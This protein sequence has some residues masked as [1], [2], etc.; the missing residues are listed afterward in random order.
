[1]TEDIKKD[2]NNIPKE[3]KFQEE[4]NELAMLYSLILNNGNPKTSIIFKKYAFHV[5][6][7]VYK[8]GYILKETNNLIEDFFLFSPKEIKISDTTFKA[9]NF[10]S[11]FAFFN[12]KKIDDDRIYLNDE[13]FNIMTIFANESKSFDFLL[14]AKNDINLGEYKVTKRVINLTLLSELISPEK[15]YIKFS[16]DSFYLSNPERDKLINDIGYHVNKKGI[17]FI[18]GPSGLGKTVTFLKF[19]HQY[20]N[21]LYINLKDIFSSFEIREIFDSLVSELSFLFNDDTKFNE[22]IQKE[23]LPI[24]QNKILYDGKEVFCELLV[25][26]IKTITIIN[27]KKGKLYIIIDQYKLCYDESLKIKNIL[28]NYTTIV[29]IICSS[30]N[31]DNIY[32]QYYKLFVLDNNISNIIYLTG[33]GGFELDLPDY[34][35]KLIKEFGDFPKYIEDISKLPENEDDIKKYRADTLDILKAKINK[36]IA[37]KI[38]YS[39]SHKITNIIK[40]MIQLEGTII[41]TYKF[42][43]LFHFIPL[44]YFIPKKMNQNNF[45]IYYAFPFIKNILLCIIN[46]NISEINSQILDD[47]IYSIQIAWNFEIL[48]QNYFSLEKKPFPDL[49]YFVKSQVEVNS[50]FDFKEIILKAEYNNQNI[51]LNEDKEYIFKIKS[52]EKNKFF[53]KLISL[54][55]ITNIS[56]KSFGESY[57]GAILIPSPS[58]KNNRNFHFLLYQVTLDRSNE[59]FIYREKILDSLSNIKILFETFFNI[60]IIDFYFMYILNYYRKGTTNVEKLCNYYTNKLYYCFYD[61]KSNKLR[62]RNSSELQWSLLKKFAKVKNFSKSYKEFIKN[63]YLSN[64]LLEDSFNKMSSELLKIENKDKNNNIE[65]NLSEEEKKEIFNKIN[66]TVNSFLNKDINFVYEDNN[67]DKIFINKK[68]MPN[69]QELGNSKKDKKK[70]YIEKNK[71]KQVVDFLPKDLSEKEKKFIIQKG[72]N[73]TFITHLQQKIEKKIKNIK[74]NNLIRGFFPINCLFVNH[75]YAILYIGFKGESESAILA[76]FSKDEEKILL[77]DLINEKDIKQEEKIFIDIFNPIFSFNNYISYMF[78]T[79]E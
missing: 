61:S 25:Q 23:L 28:A 4:P 58:T 56:Q 26:I 67:N 33:F 50:I 45:K 64:L 47:S 6:N 75:E 17:L 77:F 51:Q 71:I 14:K 55:G 59:H 46:D 38:F 22:Y 70:N 63:S 32:N 39:S 76:Y 74:I 11:L 41:D 9:Y 37:H 53:E 42:S 79:N 18:Y 78:K 69:K 24:I 3:C 30:S 21:T 68:T 52:S 72:D 62:N 16:K 12:K 15:K 49:N 8:N 34:K 43:K 73:Y 36:F 27:R 31:E 44:K 60:K 19:R 1:M 7:H 2:S 29:P 20:I 57:D 5:Q 54:D 66:I 48:V 40:E 10:E 65:N 13:K 35:L